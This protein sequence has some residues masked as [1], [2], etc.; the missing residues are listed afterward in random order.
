MSL[1][2]KTPPFDTLPAALVAPVAHEL[3]VVPL[4]GCVSSV[5]RRLARGT[6]A[7]TLRLPGEFRR[8]RRRTLV[9]V[10]PSSR[11]CIR[12]DDLGQAAR[13]RTQ[14]RQPGTRPRFRCVTEPR[15]VLVQGN[16]VRDW[17]YDSEGELS[18]VLPDGNGRVE[19]R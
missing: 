5:L 6:R 8:R 7:G 3:V 4:V 1:V 14:R 11:H 9:F 12:S 2:K 18:L 10:S 17:T 15:E 13:A 19:L 16:V